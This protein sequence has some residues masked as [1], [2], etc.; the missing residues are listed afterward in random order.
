MVIVGKRNWWLPK[1]LARILPK[2]SIEGTEC[3]GVIRTE[4]R[5][6][7]ITKDVKHRFATG[8]SREWD[9][10]HPFVGNRKPIAGQVLPKRKDALESCTRSLRSSNYR[11]ASVAEVEKELR[12]RTRAPSVVGDAPID[13]HVIG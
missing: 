11:N 1:W 4:D 9:L 6:W 13:L 8:I 5:R 10:T 2:G 3:K 12:D 7:L